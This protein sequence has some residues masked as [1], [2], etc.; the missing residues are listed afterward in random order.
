MSS[1]EI[2]HVIYSTNLN[3]LV[4]T[5]IGTFH[6]DD[7]VLVI[8]DASKHLENL[9]K[10]GFL[11]NLVKIYDNKILTIQTFSLEDSLMLLKI[12]L[13]ENEPYVQVYSLGKFI[14]DNIEE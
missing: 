12:F 7:H 1:H 9:E 11:L 4:E 3:D 13:G 2:H 5:W 8:H 10:K 14:T 6:P